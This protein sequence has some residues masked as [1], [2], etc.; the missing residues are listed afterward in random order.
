MW[1]FKQIV[2]DTRNLLRRI[3]IKYYLGKFWLKSVTR[4][5]SVHNNLIISNYLCLGRYDIVTEF[6][7]NVASCYLAS[8]ILLLT[9][10]TIILIVSQFVFSY[11]TVVV[12][13]AH[14]ISF[15][16]M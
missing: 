1:K 10:V 8:P 13:L 15:T 14:I 6:P 12:C 3:D 7:S 2:T 11:M 4:A 5:S 16:A 9:M